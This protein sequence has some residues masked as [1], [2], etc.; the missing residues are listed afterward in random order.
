MTTVVFNIRP[1]EQINSL[2]HSKP[3][4]QLRTQIWR[5]LNM[6]VFFP[7]DTDDTISKSNN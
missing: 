4:T 7:L 6:D 3:W 1:W 2:P 5:G